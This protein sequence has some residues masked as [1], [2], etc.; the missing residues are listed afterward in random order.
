MILPDW[1]TYQE[2]P[3]WVSF[4]GLE[5]ITAEYLLSDDHGAQ[6]IQTIDSLTEAQAKRLLFHMTCRVKVGAE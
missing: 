5:T 2:A 1:L 6:I 4:M 3:P